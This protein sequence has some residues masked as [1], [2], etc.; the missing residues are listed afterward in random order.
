MS[1]KR[2]KALNDYRAA[3]ESERVVQRPG[4][5]TSHPHIATWFSLMGSQDVAESLTHTLKPE[6]QR[7]ICNPRRERKKVIH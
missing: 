4:L 7:R 1:V 2:D 5:E 6:L 3:P